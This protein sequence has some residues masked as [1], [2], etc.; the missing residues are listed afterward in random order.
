MISLRG[1][2]AAIRPNAQWCLDVAAY[3]NVPVTV[4]SAVRPWADQEALRRRYESCLAKG[5]RVYAGNPD[6][7]CRY[8]AN[9]PGDSAHNFGLAWDSVVPEEYLD[10]WVAVRRYAGFRV[11]DN[12]LI[13]AE[14]PDWRVWRP[15]LKA[16]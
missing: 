10:W 7:A 3:Y 2:N 15:Y 5:E 13:H 8:P 11:P 16:A 4:T 1:L 14:Y 9:E 12:D 6:P